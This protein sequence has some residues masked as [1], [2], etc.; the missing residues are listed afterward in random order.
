MMTTPAH[1]DYVVIGCGSIGSM[2]LWQLTELALGA[3]VLGIERFDRVHTKGSYSGESR[4]F[5]V[6]L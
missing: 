1:Y 4:L 2:A 6:A 5:R 3:S